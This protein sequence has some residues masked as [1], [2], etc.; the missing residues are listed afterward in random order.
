MQPAASVNAPRGPIDCESVVRR[1]WDYLDGRLTAMTHD[2]V[3][4]HLAT[5]ELCPPHFT[6]ANDMRKALA[7]S[8]VLVS[9][10]DESRLR[11]RVHSALEGVVAQDAM[12][13]TG[14]IP[15]AVESS[16][17]EIVAAQPSDLPFLAAIE[18][19]AAK[20]LAGHLGESDI[21]EITTHEV[22]ADAL[23]RGRLWVARVDAV[24][25][26]FALVKVLEP[27]SAHLEELDVHPEHARRGLGKRLVVAVCEW[28]A[29]QGFE[30]VTLTTFRDVPFN[31]PFYARLGFEVIPSEKLGAALVAAL[32][33][34]AR[35]GMDPT[36]RVAMRRPCT[37]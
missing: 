20:L 33:E 28:A 15:D 8:P 16:V 30:A 2:E 3:E 18:T 26:G 17:Y 12:A 34:E 14:E 22:L 35:R 31:R 11:A 1:L 29:I 19:A 13:A 25:V 36:T 24:P 27:S 10:D 5:C 6:F 7:A 37:R 32:G 9:S 21:L 23:S 4:A